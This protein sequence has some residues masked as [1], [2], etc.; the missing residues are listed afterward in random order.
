MTFKIK[1]N[2]HITSASASPP[3]KPMKNSGYMPW[4]ILWLFY[5]ST[6]SLLVPCQVQSCVA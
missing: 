3:P 5:V 2:F 6:V 4:T 1:H